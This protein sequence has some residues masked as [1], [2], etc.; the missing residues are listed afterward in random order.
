[1]FQSSDQDGGDENP[2]FSRMTHQILNRLDVLED[3]MR[4]SSKFDN[5]VA[6]FGHKRSSLGGSPNSPAGVKPDKLL[7]DLMTR[8]QQ[9]EQIKRELHHIHD[10]VLKY[11]QM[12]R[13]AIGTVASPAVYRSSSD[14]KRRQEQNSLASQV[15]RE[16]DFMRKLIEK[17]VRRE[18]NA[19][20]AVKMRQK[21]Q[22]RRR[23]R[24]E[25]GYRSEGFSLS[26]SWEDVSHTEV[27]SIF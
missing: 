9:I 22:R 15:I 21:R 12:S 27:E 13:P 10:A 14:P 8:N 4:K 1:M 6:Y 7:S 17:K 16:E 11:V 2:C 3:T 19:L 24:S 18:D 25:R 23:P 5:T 26:G 20:P